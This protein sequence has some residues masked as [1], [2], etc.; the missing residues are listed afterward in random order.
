MLFPAMSV[1]VSYYGKILLGEL[2]DLRRG[3]FGTLSVVMG[4]PFTLLD[5]SP[6]GWEVV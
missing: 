6:K 2:R 1:Q 3:T 4:E 5:A